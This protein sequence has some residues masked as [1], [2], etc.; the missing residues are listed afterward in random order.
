MGPW[1]AS[2]SQDPI[3]V[4]GR[5]KKMPYGLSPDPNARRPDI[6]ITRQDFRDLESL[7]ANNAGQWNWRSVEYLVRELMRATI[8]DEG[9]IPADVVTM[10][11]RVE[12]REAGKDSPQVVTLSYPG[13]RE[14]F[15][16]AI[17]IPTP[18]GAALMGLSAGQSIC[19]AGPDGIPVT[20]EVV[21]VLY[22]PEA[23]NHR[24]FK[25]RPRSIPT[26]AQ[27]AKRDR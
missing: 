14:L 7:L 15:R 5:R 26:R 17:S 20:I 1:E 22:Q 21:K 13:E 12:Y 11:T 2:L 24:R 19:Y 8:V 6:K 10:G 18:V 16:D 25:P 4:T 3:T 27:G 9:W 23:D